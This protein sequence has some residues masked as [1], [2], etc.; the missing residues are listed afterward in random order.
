MDLDKEILRRLRTTEWIET[1]DIWQGIVK[2]TP[3]KG[4]SGGDIY[5]A[6]HRMKDEGLVEYQEKTLSEEERIR[7]NR[8]RPGVAVWRLTNSGL[9]KKNEDEPEK[10]GILDTIFRPVPARS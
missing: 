4:V 7:R 10:E 5:V 3:F 6:L 1:F 8:S 2:E 9:R